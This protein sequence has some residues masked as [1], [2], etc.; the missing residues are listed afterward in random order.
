[1]CR[2]GRASV[3]KLV[4]YVCRARAHQQLP[5]FDSSAPWAPNTLTYRD[6]AWAYCPSGAPDGHDWEQIEDA[7]VEEVR[8]EVEHRL[9][10]LR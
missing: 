10:E 7:S 8:E 4:R 5:L 6:A 2:K 9:Q 1:M 3:T